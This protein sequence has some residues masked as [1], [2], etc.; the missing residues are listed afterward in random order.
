MGMTALFAPSLTLL[1]KIGVTTS[2]LQVLRDRTSGLS[3]PGDL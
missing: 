1:G 2:Q 3:V